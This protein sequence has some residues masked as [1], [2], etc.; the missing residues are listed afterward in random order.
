MS[1]VETHTVAD[2]DD[3]IRLDRWFKAHFPRLGYWRLQKLLRTGQVRVDG[4]RAKPGL[5]LAAGQ[6]VRVPPA[7]RW[8]VGVGGRLRIYR[9]Q[10]TD[11]G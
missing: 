10:I 7:G 11:N 6:A 3:A 9:S 5:R 1:P 4:R 8:P 2:E